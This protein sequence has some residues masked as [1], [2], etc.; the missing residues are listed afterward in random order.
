MLGLPIKGWGGLKGWLLSGGKPP[1]PR[2]RQAAALLPPLLWVVKGPS[3]GPWENEVHPSTGGKEAISCHRKQA[4]CMPELKDV[5]FRHAAPSWKWHL[6]WKFLQKQTGSK[7][8][9][10]A[11]LDLRSESVQLFFTSPHAEVEGN[12]SKAELSW[13]LLVQP[14]F[15]LSTPQKW[16]H[17]FVRHLQSLKASPPRP[18]SPPP[19]VRPGNPKE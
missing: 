4:S 7:R 8:Q 15:L 6:K 1:H 14:C 19:R 2:V 12:E 5:E 9:G 10:W 18:L 17:V 11:L 13:S 3:G 16:C